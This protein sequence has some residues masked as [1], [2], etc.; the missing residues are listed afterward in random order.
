MKMKK[1]SLF[2]FSLLLVGCSNITVLDP[3]SE[4]GKD[5]AYLIWFSLALMSIVILVVFILFTWFII[6]YR[7]T[8][9]RQN[10][11]PKDVKGNLK[12]EL[13]YTILPILLLIV[14]AVPTIKITMHQSP[15][16]EA[17]QE[18]GTQIDVTAKQFEWNFEHENDKEVTDELIV[19]EKEPIVLHLQSA[20]VIHSFWVPELAGKVDVFPNKELTYVIEKPEKGTYKGKCAEFCGVQHTDMTFTVKVVSEEDYDEYLHSEKHE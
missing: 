5:Q 18:K 6:R 11:I 3:K 14:L 10:V 2:L 13:T 7:Y 15:S 12:L 4:T 9:E 1:V 20:D 17:A 16:T 8:K 19:P